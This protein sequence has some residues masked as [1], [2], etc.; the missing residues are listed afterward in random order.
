MP[1]QPDD[2]AVVVDTRNHDGSDGRERLTSARVH[3]CGHG[4]VHI[5][6]VRGPSG[7]SVAG[8]DRQRGRSQQHHD[9]V[10]C[11]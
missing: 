4:R 8:F 3:V 7:Q 1:L 9:E 10:R 11:L 5:C 2:D 6:R